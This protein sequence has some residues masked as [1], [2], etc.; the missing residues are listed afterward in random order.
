MEK[1]RTKIVIRV[2]LDRCTTSSREMIKLTTIP[3][4]TFQTMEKTKVNDIRVRSTH[5]LI[6]S[7]HY[8][9]TS[10]NS[11]ETAYLQ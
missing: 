8:Q 2:L 9:D 1:E 10:P 7:S 3:T 5:A 11:L 6:L 4:S